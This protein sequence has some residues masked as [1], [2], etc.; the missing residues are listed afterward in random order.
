MKKMICTVAAVVA[1]TASAQAAAENWQ[2]VSADSEAGDYNFVDADSVTET[3]F[4]SARVLVQDEKQPIAMA[5]TLYRCRER[6]MAITYVTIYSA[7]GAVIKS[8]PV[9]TNWTPAVPQSIGSDILK[10]VCSGSV[11][12]GVP[13]RDIFEVRRV[14]KNGSR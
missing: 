9:N 2:L 6:E 3:Q 8:W 5:K 11:I 1:L 13:L 4:W 7:E 10:R 14:L 12:Q